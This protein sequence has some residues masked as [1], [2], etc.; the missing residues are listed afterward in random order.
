MAELVVMASAPALARA[1]PYNNYAVVQ[2]IDTIIPVDIYVPGCLPR[3]DGAD[4]PT[5]A[6]G[7]AEKVGGTG[8]HLDTSKL[9]VRQVEKP[10][11]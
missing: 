7:G 8:R 1:G 2:G 6:G 3:P 5:A 10:V 4:G 9:P 11:A